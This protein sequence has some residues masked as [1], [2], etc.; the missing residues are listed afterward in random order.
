MNQQIITI[1]TDFKD[2]FASSQLQAV[3]WGLG[4]E[5]KLIENHDVADYEIVEGAYGI[6]QLAKS[7]PAGTVHL[8]VVDP[9]VGSA[10]AGIIIQTK[11]FWFVG[12]DNGLLWPAAQA[13]LEGG[14]IWRID[15]SYFGEI[16]N[17]FHGRDVFIKAAVWLTQGKQPEEFGCKEITDIVKLEFQEGQIVHIDAYGNVRVWGNKTFGLPVVKTFSDVPRGQPLVLRGSSDLFE[18]AVNLGNAKE[19]FGLKL[20]QVIERLV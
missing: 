1:T 10:R 14:R 7:C 13:H 4:F 3:V 16:S 6:W 18:L 17:T 12:P 9:G 11:K 8:G 20:G 5:G 19:D 2:Q 15:E